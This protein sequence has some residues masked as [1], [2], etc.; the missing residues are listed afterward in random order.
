MIGSFNVNTSIFNN[1]FHSLT[2]HCLSYK[3]VNMVVA[4]RSSINDDVSS[5]EQINAFELLIMVPPGVV[6]LVLISFNMPCIELRPIMIF[7]LLTCDTNCEAMLI[8]GPFL[9]PESACNITYMFGYNLY[10]CLSNH[11]LSFTTELIVDNAD[12]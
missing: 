12:H 1:D 3:S 8:G 9:R 10:K 4:T 6:L 2:R 5:E 7:V 11:I